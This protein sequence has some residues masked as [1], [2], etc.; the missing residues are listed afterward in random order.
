MGTDRAKFRDWIKI[1]F[2]ARVKAM[3]MAMA[4]I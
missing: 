2:R 1:R 3:A 4:K